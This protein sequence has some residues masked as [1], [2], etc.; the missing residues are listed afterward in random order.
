MARIPRGFSKSGVP[1]G[2]HV[3]RTFGDIGV[4][5]AAAYE[6]ANPWRHKRPKI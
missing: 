4:F 2:L 5:R 6:E 1:T 3:G